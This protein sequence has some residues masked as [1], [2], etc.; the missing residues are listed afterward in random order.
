[1]WTNEAQTHF[2]VRIGFYH[3]RIS[4]D[5][6]SVTWVFTKHYKCFWNCNLLFNGFE[7]LLNY[8]HQLVKQTKMWLRVAKQSAEWRE[9]AEMVLKI[10]TFCDYSV[11]GIQR[12]G[13]S[14]PF[15]LRMLPL[16]K[17]LRGPELPLFYPHVWVWLTIAERN[18]SLQPTRWWSFSAHITDSHFAFDVTSHSW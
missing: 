5:T 16:A 7:Y 6:V 8:A 17:P 15:L 18:M 3:Q 10:R 9:A 13:P 12:G 14:G 2:G 11:V 4:G 1:M